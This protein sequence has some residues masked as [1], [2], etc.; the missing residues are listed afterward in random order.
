MSNLAIGVEPQID[1]R[2]DTIGLI[3]KLGKGYNNALQGLNNALGKFSSK[4][5]EKELEEDKYCVT[6]GCE[7]T[8]TNTKLKMCSDCQLIHHNE[9]L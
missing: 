2:P 5:F 6:E 4:E 8:I 7:G 9:N 1:Y 3:K